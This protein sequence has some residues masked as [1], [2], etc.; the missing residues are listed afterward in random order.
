MHE[1]AKAGRIVAATADIY[2][3]ER[4]GAIR[5]WLDAE[6]WDVK[7]IY[8]SNIQDVNRA[9]IDWKKLGA[10]YGIREQ[11]I[12]HPPGDGLMARIFPRANHSKAFQEVLAKGYDVFAKRG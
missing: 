11:K 1:A 4:L 10:C 6:Q 12:L 9:E 7:S 8:A 5:R 2:D 3:R